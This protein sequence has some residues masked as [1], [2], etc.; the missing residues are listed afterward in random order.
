MKIMKS[1]PPGVLGKDYALGRK[2]KRAWKY[3]AKRRAYEVIR[4]IYKYHPSKINSIL[5][6]G[7]A[8]GL[9][10]GFIKKIFS[11][12]ECI[13]LEYSQELIDMNQDKNIKPIQGDAQNLPFENNS[14]DIAVA[15]AI[16]E[17]LPDPKKML[18]EAKRVL[19]PNG[20]II[21]TSPDPLWERVATM[22]GH[23]ADDQH[24]K[25]MNLRELVSLFNEIGYEVLEQKKFMLSPIGM[26]LEIP[27]E[28]VVRTFG[29]NFL[30]ASQLVVGK[31][32]NSG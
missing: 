11:Q 7:A 31:K 14:F 30:F 22:V 4:T 19:R 28:R 1:I 17:H 6:I 13:G 9:M 21:L 10:L 12:A 5:D 8:E 24:C 32:I 25:L 15:A 16:I 27:I 20:I 18:E 26:P 23:L 2:T 29:L 3:R